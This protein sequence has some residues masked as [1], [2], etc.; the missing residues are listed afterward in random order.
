MIASILL[1]LSNVDK[2]DFRIINKNRFSVICCLK[3]I[4]EINTDKKYE[5]I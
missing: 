4:A 3:I 5:I 2:E 1:K